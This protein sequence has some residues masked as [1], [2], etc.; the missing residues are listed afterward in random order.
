MRNVRF[1]R[2]NSHLQ[3]HDVAEVVANIKGSTIGLD[4]K[5]GPFGRIYVVSKKATGASKTKQGDDVERNKIADGDLIVSVNG[6]HLAK[7]RYDGKI[8]G[9]KCSGALLETS[10]TIK[11]CNLPFRIILERPSY[12]TTL[13][14]GSASFKS[15]FCRQFFDIKFGWKAGKQILHS[16]N[17]RHKGEEVALETMQQ[18][19][20]SNIIKMLLFCD[21]K[22]AVAQTKCKNICFLQ[23][24][25]FASAARFVMTAECPKRLAKQYARDF[26]HA[27]ADTYVTQKS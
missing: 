27:Y 21:R 26:R 13:K 8:E 19:T 22:D 15:L 11:S 25:L 5:A 18:G 24:M 14:C 3:E 17:D 20:N 10:A 16:Y 23:E 9:S 1:G 4:I 2:G 7:I 12:I 6:K